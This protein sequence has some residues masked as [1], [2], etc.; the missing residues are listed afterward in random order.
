MDSGDCGARYF[1]DVE[2]GNLDYY[3]GSKAHI[4]AGTFADGDVGINTGPSCGREGDYMEGYICYLQRG[5]YNVGAPSIPG[6]QPLSHYNQYATSWSFHD[7]TDPMLSAEQGCS[8]GNPYACSTTDEYKFVDT[9]EEWGEPTG[10]IWMTESG[11]HHVCGAHSCGYYNFP[12][13]ACYDQYHNAKSCYVLTATQE[14]DAAYDW[15]SYLP[16]QIVAH[17][18]WYEYV[19][20]DDYSWGGGLTQGS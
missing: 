15:R 7:Y 10:D 8:P 13:S 1:G 4:I 14:A 2:Q 18:F 5:D 6:G 19:S 3:G 12:L 20:T 11:Y 9:L 17:M 16:A